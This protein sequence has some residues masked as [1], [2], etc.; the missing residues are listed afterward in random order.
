MLFV[1]Y[2]NN[3]YSNVINQKPHNACIYTVILH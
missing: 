1:P 3:N 2:I